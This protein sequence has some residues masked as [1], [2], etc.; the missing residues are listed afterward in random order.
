MSGRRPT[1]PLA[2]LLALLT[3][4][5]ACGAHRQ[6]RRNTLDW[7]AS[8]ALGAH[9]TPTQSAADY[10]RRLAGVAFAEAA[11]VAADADSRYVDGDRPADAPRPRRSSRTTSRSPLSAQAALNAGGD[12][13]SLVPA[14][15]NMLLSERRT[16]ESM[17]ADAR[18]LGDHRP[19]TPLR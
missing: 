2:G 4:R 15:N 17:I 18:L 6:R 14:L 11:P 16:V 1:F 9:K 13:A 5:H 3:S 19:R 8:L 7:R 10:K 12:A